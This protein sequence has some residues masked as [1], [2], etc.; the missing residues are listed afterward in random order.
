MKPTQNVCENEYGGYVMSVDLWIIWLIVA[1]AALIIESMTMGLTSVWFAAGSLTAMV[2]DLCGCP[3][4]AQIVTMAAVTAVTFA[5]CLIWIKPQFDKR[6]GSEI[7]HTNID[8]Y[9]GKEGIVIKDINPVLGVGQV[10]VAGQVWSAKAESSI[11]EGT[12][13]TVMGIEGVKFI[14]EAK[15]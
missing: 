4:V 15:Q 13:V 2:L 11:P 12:S 1:I 6:R 9:I 8:S 3:M 7:L 14:V 10:K 5:V